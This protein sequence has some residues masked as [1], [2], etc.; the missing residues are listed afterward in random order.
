MFAGFALGL[1]SASNA[2]AVHRPNIVFILADDL[3]Y[4]DVN[5]F[6]ARI[7]GAKPARMFYET[8]NLDRLAREGTAFGQAYS[9][10]LCSPTRAGLL[11]GR[12]SAKLG[13]MTASP[14][15]VRT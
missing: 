6:A 2:A 15:T 4:T 12:N 3:G 9:T 13:V 10:Q 5:A 7:T 1:A 11:T 14:A 8:P